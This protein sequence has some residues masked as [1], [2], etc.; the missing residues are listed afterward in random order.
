MSEET[1]ALQPTT[2]KFS[3]EEWSLVTEKMTL[4]DFGLEAIFQG[5]PYV[6]F[7]EGYFEMGKP[8]VNVTFGV[9]NEDFD[10]ENSHGNINYI[11][12]YAKGLAEGYR[13]GL[14]DAN[15]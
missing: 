9:D 15:T 2:S 7:T 4:V 3:T 5:T 10:P 8:M 1:T 12:A 14:K 13:R 6:H 11:L